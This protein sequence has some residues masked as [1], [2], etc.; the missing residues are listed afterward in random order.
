MNHIL[1]EISTL[2]QDTKMVMRMSE[3]AR[4]RHRVEAQTATGIFTNDLIKK[5][6][7]NL[8]ESN[9]HLENILL[10]FFE[11]LPNPEAACS[12]LSA[13]EQKVL[14]DALDTARA[15]KTNGTN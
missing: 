2:D 13:E 12:F 8:L 5:G 4:N 11:S 1:P 15:R 6:V 10:H 9:T 14:E 3:Y 7:K